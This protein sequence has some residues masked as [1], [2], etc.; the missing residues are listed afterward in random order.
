MQIAFRVLWVVCTAFTPTLLPA[1]QN[2]DPQE[3]PPVIR[4]DVDVVN[5]LV[6]VH[7]KKRDTYATDLTIDDFDVY[8][9]GVKQKIEFFNHETGED[10]QPLTIV[11]LIDTSGSVKDKLRFEQQAAS[12]FLQATLRKNV[13]LAAVIQ[14][15]SEVNLV[16]DFTY[17]FDTLENSILEIRAGGATRLYDSVFLAVEDLLAGEV[18]RKVIVILSDGADTQS[19]VTAEQAIR[20]AQNQDVVIYG[21]GV[22]SPG[23]DSDFGKIRDFA[24][25]TGGIFF[26][27]KARL[28]RLR[29]AFQQINREIKNQYSIGYIST[30]PARDGTFR[31]IS[32]RVRRSGLKVTHRKGYYAGDPTS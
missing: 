13:D 28:S 3:P 16:Q 20:V 12:E 27:S 14:F 11:L 30:N 2:P 24:A 4:A 32:V 31:K 15:D 9:D 7:D 19:I 8:E 29:D 1:A 18:G 10:A 6:T 21:I 26:K 5:V 23:F 17:D 25:A 22:R